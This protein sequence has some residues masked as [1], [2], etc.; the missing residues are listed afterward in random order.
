MRTFTF[1]ILFV[2]LNFQL[3]AQNAQKQ[4]NRV[5]DDWHQAAAEANDEAYFSLM[6]KDAIFIGTDP[7][8]NWERKDFESKFIKKLK[9]RP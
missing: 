1:L 5:V 2:G 3:S 8:E 9:T 7:T 4:I 6:T